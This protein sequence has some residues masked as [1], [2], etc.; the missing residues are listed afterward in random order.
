MVVYRRLW[1]KKCQRRCR[2][3]LYLLASLAI[4]ETNFRIPRCA[5]YTD[6]PRCA[7]YGQ[8]AESGDRPKQVTR[9][10]MFDKGT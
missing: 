9:D 3:I 10:R 8:L 7:E 5:E 6:V 2:A 1:A 4:G